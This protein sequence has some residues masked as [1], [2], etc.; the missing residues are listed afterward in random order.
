MSTQDNTNAESRTNNDEVTINMN[1]EP[2]SAPNEEN[3]TNQ[4]GSQRSLS[5]FQF[6]ISRDLLLNNVSFH[7]I[8][9]KEKVREDTLCD[10]QISEIFTSL[11]SAVTFI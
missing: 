1:N 5:I 8:D 9:E 10:S 3:N 6:R 4:S 2:P 11:Q 7:V